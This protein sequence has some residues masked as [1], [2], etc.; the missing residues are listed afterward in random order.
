M[1]RPITVLISPSLALLIAL[2]P[3]AFAQ[4][5]IEARIPVSDPDY[6]RPT[7]ETSVAAIGS[8]L[9][10]MWNVRKPVNNV[11]GPFRV[12][13]AVSDDG[14]ETWTDMGYFPLP[15]GC[16][17]AQFDPTV[18]GDPVSGTFV[19]ACVEVCG[20]FAAQV[21][22]MPQGETEFEGAVLLSNGGSPC[23][24][25][26]TQLAAGPDPGN[27]QAPTQ[28]Y[29]TCF[30][31]S[32]TP[33]CNL[34]LALHYYDHGQEQWTSRFVVSNP[35][36]GSVSA[37]WPTVAP[38]GVLCIA[39]TDQ[40]DP[41][42]MKINVVATTTPGATPYTNLELEHARIPFVFP[43]TKQYGHYIGG[44]FPVRHNVQTAADPGNPDVL[45]VVYNDFVT[46]PENQ[47]DDGDVD[48]FLIR[49]EYNQQ[50]EQWDWSGRIRINDDDPDV[51]HDQFF[52]TIAVDEIGDLHVAWFDTRNDP[53]DPGE[54]VAI[55]L[56]YAIS[57][58][59]GQSFTNYE[60][61]EVAIDTAELWDPGFLGDY[62]RITV[63]DDAVVIVYNATDWI[64]SPAFPLL[65][66]EV[67]MAA[68][69][70]H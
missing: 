60:V 52:P 63:C 25:D 14:G 31:L 42:A 3:V 26:Y 11:F 1:N 70:M 22:I 50:N 39:Y 66:G 33:A 24:S 57:T 41:D 2:S 20:V 58:D 30:T 29:L 36:T 45:Y 32:N 69:I 9:V 4:P 21:G 49:G 59:G 55:S 13:Y 43:N 68:R 5:T 48:V 15:E 64:P 65:R 27:P 16:T 17:G 8:K 19:G 12:G 62:I 35:P 67:I 38:D 28:F 53:Q 18:V 61:D 51:Q 34:R 23:A 46:A 44:D 6:A 56:F 54:D 7:N 40:S 47:N 10:A 37:P